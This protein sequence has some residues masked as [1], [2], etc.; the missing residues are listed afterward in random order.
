MKRLPM[1]LLSIIAVVFAIT[2]GAAP[3]VEIKEAPVTW[4][5]VALGD[6]EQLYVEL[7]AVCHGLDGRGNGPAAPALSAPLPDLTRLALNNDGEFPTKEVQRAIRG[8]AAIVAHGTSEMPVWGRVFRDVRP[9]LKI[10]LREGF[11]ELRIFHL[12]TYVES[13]QVTEEAE[14]QPP[15][16][17]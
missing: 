4:K 8:E 7:C 14:P 3:Q 17:S 9:D 15:E 2:L 13:L 16:E 5:Q 6:G 11:A 1:L 12:T 10:S